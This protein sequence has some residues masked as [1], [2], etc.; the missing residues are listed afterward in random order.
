L[1]FF[2]EK[3]IILSASNKRHETNKQTNKNLSID[4]KKKFSQRHTN[5]VET[6]KRT[7]TKRQN[8]Y[9][10]YAWKLAYT[11]CGSVFS[12][13]PWVPADGT[14]DAIC[15]PPLASSTS[16][17]AFIVLELQGSEVFFVRQ[18]GGTDEG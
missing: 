2:Y 10:K 8:K 14:N 15:R 16:D 17:S 1:F 3:E 12:Q 7:T 9:K 18:T 6:D 13:A 5:G 4:T 11:P